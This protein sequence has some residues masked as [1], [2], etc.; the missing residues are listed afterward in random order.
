M[1]VMPS[2]PLLIVLLS[3]PVSTHMTST[4]YRAPGVLQCVAVCC[5]ALQCDAGCCSV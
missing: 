4:L 1:F 2:I 3:S 5:S